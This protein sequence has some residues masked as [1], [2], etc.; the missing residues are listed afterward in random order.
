MHITKEMPIRLAMTRGRNMDMVRQ[1]NP[2][3]RQRKHGAG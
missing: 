2:Q 1:V 3:A